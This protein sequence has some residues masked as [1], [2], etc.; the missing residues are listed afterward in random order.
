MQK[1]CFDFG[2]LDMEE[3]ISRTMLL[4]KTVDF[5]P[6]GV[7]CPPFSRQLPAGTK[8]IITPIFWCSILQPTPTIS[9]SPFS[10][11]LPVLKQY[12]HPVR[13]GVCPVNL[14]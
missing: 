2:S 6:D 10:R 9:S 8:S 14:P 1:A 5:C 4:C 11:R 13:L 12:Q 3:M 7:C